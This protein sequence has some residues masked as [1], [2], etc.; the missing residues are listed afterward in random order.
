MLNEIR[1][2]KNFRTF[3]T[4]GKFF[5]AYINKEAH[6][7]IVKDNHRSMKFEFHI[8]YYYEFWKYGQHM[9]I[10]NASK[11]IKRRLLRPLWIVKAQIYSL[12]SRWKTR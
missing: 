5:R 11:V 9:I 4:K 6:L 3:A 2:L 7:S 12:S 1:R 8:I 10:Q